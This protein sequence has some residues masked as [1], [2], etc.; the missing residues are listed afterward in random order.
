MDDV[1]PPLICSEHCQTITIEERT[2]RLEIYGTGQNDWIL[3]VVDEHGTSTVWDGLF[4]TDED[5]YLEFNR[6]LEAEGIQ[7]LLSGTG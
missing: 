4:D 2:V 1:E 6:T 5:A 3:E 7:S